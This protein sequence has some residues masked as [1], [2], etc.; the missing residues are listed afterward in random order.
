MNNITLAAD[1]ALAD[2]ADA[3]LADAAREFG[4]SVVDTGGRCTALWMTVLRSSVVYHL[5]VTDD[6]GVSAPETGDTIA[7]GIYF[8][9]NGSWADMPIRMA[10]FP[11]FTECL[12][13][14]RAWMQE[15]G[16]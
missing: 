6:S 1:A 16:E 9:D 2:A 4:F 5:V 11:N 3:A 14:I 15:G 10:E 7:M 8:D 12:A 13:V